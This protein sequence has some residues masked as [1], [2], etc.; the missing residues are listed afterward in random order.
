MARVTVSTQAAPEDF[1]W[2][3]AALV[4]WHVPAR[5]HLQGVI[6]EQKPSRVVAGL[7]ER[8]GPRNP[9]ETPLE[10]STAE[11]AH[12]LLD[13]SLALAGG[14]LRVPVNAYHDHVPADVVSLG[15]VYA[16]VT[17]RCIV[18]RADL[19]PYFGDPLLYGIV[20]G[21]LGVMR[22]PFYRMWPRA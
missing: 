8:P 13:G 15:D 5:G 4:Q 21:P 6:T 18:R 2:Y 16:L 19:V 10:R 22:P 20:V 7:Q 1:F 11:F 9:D 3:D 14:N 17:P 12:T